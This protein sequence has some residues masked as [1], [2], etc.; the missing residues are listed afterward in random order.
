[1]KIAF[2]VL[3]WFLGLLFVLLFLLA[4]Y[5][6]YYFSSLFLLL[7]VILLVPPLREF[8]S[9]HLGIPLPLWV[10]LTLT[11]VLFFLFVS[12]V[13]RGMGNPDSIYK[14]PEIEQRLMAIYEAKMEQ[15]PVPY[16]SRTIRTSYGRIYI[17][18]SG[19]EKAPPVFLLHASAMAS[20]SW[21]NNIEGLNRHYRTYAIDTIGDAGRSVLDDVTR[22]PDDGQKLAELYAE[23]MDSL[24]I[25]MAYFIGASQGGFIATHMALYRPERVKKLILCGPMG[26]TGTISSV[27]RILLTTMFP[28][29]PVQKSTIHW[30]FGTDP[31][32]N[33]MVKDWFEL[34]LEGVISRQA[35]PQ[36]FTQQDLHRLPMPVLL[37]LGQRDGLV[38]NPEKAIRLVKSVPRIQVAILD[39]GHLIGA[40]KP[41][42]FNQK[43]IDFIETESP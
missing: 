40:E 1:M 9:Q 38:G 8:V 21:L 37:L 30:A 35:R 39:T 18:V 43:V 19:P 28:V 27:L 14:N 22:F 17:I 11:P 24:G 23:I 5:S 3:N 4:L 15:W 7:I 10:R 41:D 2:A 29:K 12:L 6:R 13:F 20:W 16:K 31:R 42:Q 36:P 25:P 33:H 26:Y 32:V 34:I